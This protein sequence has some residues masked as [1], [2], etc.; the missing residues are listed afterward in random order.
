EMDA[1]V[2]VICSLRTR[3]NATAHVNRLPPEILARIFDFV[4]I[5]YPLRAR[6][7]GKKKGA[8][9]GWLRVSYVCRQWRS[10]ALNHSHLWSNVDLGMGSQ[11]PGIFLSRARS[12]PILFKY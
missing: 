7:R 10:T 2:L 8:Y 12:A 5:I 6:K 1:V 11:W 3:F 4:Q 9:V